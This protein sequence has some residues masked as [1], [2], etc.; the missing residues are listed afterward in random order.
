MTET[1]TGLCDVC[2][3]RLATTT[4]WETV[5]GET[6][7]IAACTRCADELMD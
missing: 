7:S 4:V 2:E 3:T 6:K 1:K 5:D